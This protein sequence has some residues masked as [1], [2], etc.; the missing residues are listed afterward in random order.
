[1]FLGMDVG[2]KHATVPL[3]LKRNGTIFGCAP[4]GCRIRSI[5]MQETNHATKICKSGSDFRADAQEM[6][7][8][9]VTRKSGQQKTRPG[10]SE[11]FVQR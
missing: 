4:R 6:Q 1:M 7:M 3:A 8:L 10:I 2:A 11:G 9:D 5:E